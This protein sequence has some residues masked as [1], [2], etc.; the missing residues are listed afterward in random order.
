M[1]YRQGTKDYKLTYKYSN[2]LQV[3][4]YSDSDFARCAD[5]RKSTPGY[6]FALTRGLYLGKVASKL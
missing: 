2:N 6:I 3:I 5:T 4:G 1:S